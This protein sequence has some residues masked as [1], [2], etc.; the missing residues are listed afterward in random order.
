MESTEAKVNLN[1]LEKEF[2]QGLKDAENQNDG[3][4]RDSGPTPGSNSRVSFPPAIVKLVVDFKNRIETKII[5]ADM[6]EDTVEFIRKCLETTPREVELYQQVFDQLGSDYA[7]ES[8]KET[9][10]KLLTGPMAIVALILEHEVTRLL[11]AR[12]LMKEF[13][14]NKSKAVA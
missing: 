13:E 4:P 2:S 11:N 12:N 9:L 6:D 8:F 5:T 10:N 3:S 14:R 1:Q 7:P